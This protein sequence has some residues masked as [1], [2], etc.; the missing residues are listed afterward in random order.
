MYFVRFFDI[1]PE[2]IGFIYLKITSSST[3]YLQQY[4]IMH[5]SIIIPTYNNRSLLKRTLKPLVQ[6]R[7]IDFEI[8]VVDDSTSNIIESYISRLNIKNLKYYHNLPSF[9]AVKNWNYGL[10]LAKGEY[11]ILLH[12]D[13]YFMD[14]RH[15]LHKCLTRFENSENDIIIV[16]SCVNFTDGSARK[17]KIP[18]KIKSFILNHF[19]SML[20]VSNIIGPTSCVVIKRD[21]V[22]PFN[23]KLKWLVD[24][25]WYYR[26]IKNRKIALNNE[27]FIGSI[28]GH[29]GQITNSLNIKETGIA[30][31][32][33]LRNYYGK[34]SIVSFALIL[35][36]LAYFVKGKLFKDY[37]PIWGKS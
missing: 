4:T 26:I 34:W 17:Q 35:R 7:S 25:D 27:L 1:E 8:L 20:F 31:Q 33:E 19:P 15:F 29:E 13:E 21:L 5:F 9:G 30:D 3:T 23:E 37:N 11:I 16:N 6:Q 28:H 24:I 18:Y 12:H 32:L 2:F 36:S 22:E 14:D 10:T